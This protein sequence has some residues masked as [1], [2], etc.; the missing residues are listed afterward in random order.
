VPVLRWPAGVTQVR[1]TLAPGW[2]LD[3]RAVRLFGEP[4]VWPF[5]LVMTEPAVRPA[6]VA[7]LPQIVPRTRVPELTEAIADGTVRLPSLV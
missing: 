1:E 3:M 5:T 6:A 7:G 4:T 2:N